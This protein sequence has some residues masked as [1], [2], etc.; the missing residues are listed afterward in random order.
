MAE[1]MKTNQIKPAESDLWLDFLQRV[2]ALKE[3][4]LIN[5]DYMTADMNVSR[6]ELVD[7]NA[8]MLFELDADYGEFVKIGGDNIADKIGFMPMTFGD[9]YIDVVKGAG[10]MGFWIPEA[11]KQEDAAREFINTML[12]EEYLTPIYEKSPG[13]CPIEGFDLPGSPWSK[14]MDMF[15][16]ELP[17]LDPWPDAYLSIMDLGS[18]RANL[19]QDIF[20][21]QDPKLA[22]EDWYLEYSNLCKAKRLEGF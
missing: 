1:K 6:Q 17:T 3:K 13:S 20:A 19:F 21:G 22:L 18:K 7:G 9:N 2:L 15:A 10:S 11:T 16:K 4:G 5:E 12:T 14:E 8:A